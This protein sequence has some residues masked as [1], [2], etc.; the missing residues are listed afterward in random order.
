M[1]SFLNPDAPTPTPQAIAASLRRLG[2]V[3]FVLQALLGVIPILTVVAT[4][5]FSP[6]QRQVGF[7]LGLWSAIAC[8]VLL[9]FCIYWCFHYTVLARRLEN[10]ADRP[11]K[12]QVVQDLKWGVTANLGV[13]AIA[14]VIA[15]FRV[16]DLTFK[17]LTLPQAATVI[18]PNPVGTA[19]ASPGALIAPSNMIAIQAMLNAIAAGL[20]GTVVSLLL[21]Y[22][23][24]QH[25]NPKN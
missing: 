9:G 6:I 23:V 18:T 12:S 24:G 10:P 5:L 15:L 2:W 17:M 20:V 19:I 21:L 13:I 22:Q 25:R 14:V 1:F 4:A 11:A 8:L 3:G 7:S 16:G